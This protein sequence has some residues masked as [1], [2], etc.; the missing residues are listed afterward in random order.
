[1]NLE[2]EMGRIHS[3]IVA[4]GSDLLATDD[5]LPFADDYPVQMGI[6]RIGIVDLPLLNPGMADNHHISPGNMN[7]ACK[8]D[9]AVSDG[10]DG[11]A[12]PPGTSSVRYPVLS[13]MTSG[14]KAP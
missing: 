1:M 10:M 5:L 7:V 3:V 6:E 8:N 9:H 13:E 4:N 12:K 11:A 14:T 2:M